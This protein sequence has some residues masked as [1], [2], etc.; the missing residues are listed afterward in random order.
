MSEVPDKLLPGTPLEE[1]EEREV[2]V[3]PRVFIC[4]FPKSGTHLV[5]QMVQPFVLPMP[6]EK[7]WAGTFKD[8]SWTTKW[9][10]I[11][12]TLKRIGY[13]RDGTYAKGHLGYTSEIEN[14]LYGIGAAVLFVYRDPRDVAV[15]LTH[16]ILDGRTHSHNEWY[17]E[18]GF[19]AALLAVIKGLGPYTGVMERW[20]QYADWLEVP[21]VLGLKFNDLI[22]D[23]ESWCEKILRYVVGHCAAHRGYKATI[24]E[25]VLE[26]AI[27][28]MVANS[29]KKE[30]S[31]TYRKGESG[32]WKEEFK[33]AHIV[34]FQ[35]SDLKWAEEYGLEEPWLVHLGFEEDRTWGQQP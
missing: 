23:K 6:A 9:I 27:D 5:E 13:V 30:R 7:P 2:V 31:P 33:T 29:E 25:E 24:A 16:H 22:T 19:D 34:A 4:S 11:K 12:K 3:D 28:D 21:W 20:N 1:G 15:S 14:Y 32:G 35:N 8:H 26:K 17:Q 10:A 18:V